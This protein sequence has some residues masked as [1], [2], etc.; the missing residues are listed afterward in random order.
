MIKQS[1]VHSYFPPCFLAGNAATVGLALSAC[2][3]SS[4]FLPLL[5]CRQRCDRGPGSERLLCKLIFSHHF[6]AGNAATVG[7]VL[8][9]C[10][11]VMWTPFHV[12][13]LMIPHCDPRTG[14]SMCVD[15]EL[16]SL[17][18]WCGY[19]TAGVIPLLILLDS[20]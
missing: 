17:S 6:L 18:E 13:T 5:P 4:Y 14:G 19:S 15:P 12:L 9:G 2:H 7:L 1:H 16:W 3:V 10:Q 8:S 11:I 20:R